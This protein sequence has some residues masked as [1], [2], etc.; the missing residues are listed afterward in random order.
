MGINGLGHG[1]MGII[2]VHPRCMHRESGCVQARQG[3]RCRWEK[4]CGQEK[5]HGQGQWLGQGFCLKGAPFLCCTCSSVGGS[6]V[7]IGLCPFA[8]LFFYPIWVI[9]SVL[10]IWLTDV[11]GHKHAVDFAIGT[12]ANML[13]PHSHGCLRPRVLIGGNVFLFRKGETITSWEKSLKPRLNCFEWIKQICNLQITQP[14][15]NELLR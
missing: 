8:W 7:G 15:C 6:R 9:G 4:E 12:L 10:T 11:L 14:F 2:C 1:G 5:R 3:K 13:Y